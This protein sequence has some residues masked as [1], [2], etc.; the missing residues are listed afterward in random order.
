MLG[1]GLGDKDCGEN[2]ALRSSF[3]RIRKTRTHRNG[4]ACASGKNASP[5]GAVTRNKTAAWRTWRR[6]VKACA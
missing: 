4:A 1:P 5:E 3:S 6:W 2:A